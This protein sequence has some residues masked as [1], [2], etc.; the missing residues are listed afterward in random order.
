MHNLRRPAQST[1]A[2]ALV[3]GLCGASVSSCG[4]DDRDAEA[5][6]A[7]WSRFAGDPGGEQVEQYDSLE[8]LVAI[9]D[10]VVRG[11]V[12]EVRPGR[13]VEGTPGDVLGSVE[14]LIEGEVIAGERL[15]TRPGEPLV[16]EVFIGDERPPEGEVAVDPVEAGPPTETAIFFLRNKGSAAELFGARI[17]VDE[18]RDFY[19]L[20]RIESVVVDVDGASVNPAAN[21]GADSREADVLADLPAFDELAG[22]VERLD[23]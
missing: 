12:V 11:R 15:D 19:R 7:P 22:D 18:E 8:H 5:L 3:L 9:S 21:S 6:S 16:M 17:D 10:T 23:G 1:I 20:V 14:W 13:T 2:L 4:N